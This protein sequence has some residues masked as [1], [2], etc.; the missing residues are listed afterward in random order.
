M[1]II[2]QE[3]L[4]GQN[5][6]TDFHAFTKFF[7]TCQTVRNEIDCYVDCM[8]FILICALTK[9]MLLIYRI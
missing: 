7:L 1:F 8:Y 9:S 4:L 3:H 5:D 6:P 2:F